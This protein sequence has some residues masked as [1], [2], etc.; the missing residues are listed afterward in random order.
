MILLKYLFF[1]LKKWKFKVPKVDCF[2]ESIL[3]YLMSIILSLI[4]TWWRIWCIWLAFVTSFV[5]SKMAKR[6]RKFR[7]LWTVAAEIK[8]KTSFSASFSL[9]S[10]EVMFHPKPIIFYSKQSVHNYWEWTRG[11]SSAAFELLGLS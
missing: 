2:C 8:F 6:R 9:L 5:R 10:V 4:W 11:D 1:H 3:L 7:L